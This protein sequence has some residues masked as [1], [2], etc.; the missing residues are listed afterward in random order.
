MSKIM[1]PDN[2]VYPKDLKEP[3]LIIDPGHKITTSGKRSPDGQLLEFEAVQDVSER[4][5]E[6]LDAH[7]V[8]VVLTKRLNDTFNGMTDKDDLYRRVA[9][10]NL[11]WTKGYR[12]IYFMSTHFN[13]HL[14]VWTNARGYEVFTTGSEGG[15]NLAKIGVKYLDKFIK[16][17]GSWARGSFNGVK[18][19]QQELFFVIN[20][21]KMPAVL[22]EFEFYTNKEACELIKS[23]NFRDSCAEVMICSALEAFKIPYK[24]YAIKE[25]VMV[26][27][28]VDVPKDTVM[29]RVILDGVQV[30]SLSVEANAIAKVKE[31]V[32]SGKNQIGKVQRNT[33]RKDIFVYSIK[34]LAIN[35]ETQLCRILVNGKSVIAITGKTKAELYAKRN[36]KGIIKI[37]CVKDSVIVS[38]FTVTPP[39][40]PVVKPVVKPAVKPAITKCPTDPELRRYP[41]NGT[42]KVTVRSGIKFRDKPCTCHGKQLG[43]MGYA[44]IIKYD[45]VVITK[46]YVWICWVSKSGQKVYMPIKENATSNRWGTCY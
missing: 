44:A 16:P 42:C 12:N 6:V 17:Y 41:E 7:N 35:Y 27:P 31:A 18:G 20:K 46:K 21:T 37:Q 26:K 13:A 1:Y 32:N 33:D 23:S 28:V 2:I 34:D 29:Y 22:F 3:I 15:F 10:A 14:P 5:A 39:V 43:I 30:T 19:I 36:Y 4:V 38:E 45:S 24:G 9:L 8:T 40:V 11:F 25:E